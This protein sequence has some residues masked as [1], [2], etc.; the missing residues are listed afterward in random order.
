MKASLQMK[1]GISL[2]HKKK[3]LTKESDTFLPSLP[4][5]SHPEI[6]TE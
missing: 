2:W 5:Y 6:A 1:E 4:D 3:P